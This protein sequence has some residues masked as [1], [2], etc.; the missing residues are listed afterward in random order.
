MTY[1]WLR[2]FE[3]LI[4]D[5]FGWEYRISEWERKDFPTSDSMAWL[6]GQAEM[7]EDMVYSNWED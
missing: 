2:A 7:A 5:R 1:R 4:K 3:A 6:Y